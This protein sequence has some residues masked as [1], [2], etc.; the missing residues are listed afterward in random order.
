MNMITRKR[1]SNFAKYRQET[2][3]PRGRFMMNVDALSGHRMIASPIQPSELNIC[4]PLRFLS[5]E[6]LD[7]W[8]YI[9]SRVCPS[10]SPAGLYLSV[11]PTLQSTLKHSALSSVSPPAAARPIVVVRR[12]IYQSVIHVFRG[13]KAALRDLSP[14][15]GRRLRRV[16]ISF[17]RLLSRREQTSCKIRPL[18]RAWNN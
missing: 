8:I 3:E 17:H 15:K 4:L 10:A 11:R 5:F 12:R 16:A 6:S 7:R 9:C 2:L 18:G 14:R 1:N 13:A